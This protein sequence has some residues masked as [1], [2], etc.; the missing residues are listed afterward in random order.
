MQFKLSLRDSQTRRRH[1][2]RNHTFD[3]SGILSQPGSHKD[4]RQ[5]RMGRA[6]SKELAQFRD[7]FRLKAAQ[8]AAV[9]NKKGKRAKQKKKVHAAT[10]APCMNTVARACTHLTMT[11]P[12]ADRSAVCP[13]PVDPK[14][15]AVIAMPSLPIEAFMR[16]VILSKTWEAMSPRE[17]LRSFAESSEKSHGLGRVAAPPSPTASSQ[18]P[19]AAKVPDE[20]VTMMNVTSFGETKLEALALEVRTPAATLQGSRRGT[21]TTRSAGPTRLL[22]PL[23]T[24]HAHA[25][26]ACTQGSDLQQMQ[27]RTVISHGRVFPAGLR[28]DSSNMDPLMGWRAGFQMVALNLQTNDIPTQLHQCAHNLSNAP[29]RCAPPAR[30]M[31]CTVPAP[32]P[33]SALFELS[34]GH[35]YVLKPVEMRTDVMWPPARK[36]VRRVTVEVISLHHLPARGEHRPETSKGKRSACHQ[37]ENHLSGLSVPPKAS[38][39][40]LRSPSVALELHAIVSNS[41]PK[42]A[43]P[44]NTAP[45]ACSAHSGPAASLSAGW[46]LLRE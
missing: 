28:T 35:G 32:V 4:L 33:C 11:L 34:G 31:L 46:L 19:A 2:D 41:S 7:D 6:T 17:R 37:Y 5:L 18:S 38:A 42:H 24:P 21:L 22:I 12:A 36:T 40:S 3:L 30:R 23:P 29:A 39:A 10:S 25:L 45:N 9:T 16:P 27:R 1:R 13:Q 8:A 20:A 15:A 43:P 26:F 14:L 44:A